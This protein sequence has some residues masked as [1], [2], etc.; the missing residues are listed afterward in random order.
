MNL[1]QHKE[2]WEDFE[3]WYI[4]FYSRYNPKARLINA[5]TVIGYF[6]DEPFE[7]QLGVYIKYFGEKEISIFDLW[8][9]MSEDFKPTDPNR[10][11]ETG[12]DFE[13]SVEEC[14]KTR[15]EQLTK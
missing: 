11:W 10:K 5:G 7:M 12:Y 2:A 8:F 4:G 9:L 13:S 3:V 1:Q 15:N 6:K 14:F